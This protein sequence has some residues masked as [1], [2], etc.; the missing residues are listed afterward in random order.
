MRPDL[1]G[2]NFEFKNFY[3]GKRDEIAMTLRG[4]QR[5]K[6]WFYITPEGLAQPV[7]IN[8]IDTAEVIEEKG[9]AFSLV[10]NPFLVQF[11]EYDT[12]QRP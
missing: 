12:F 4:A 9:L 5:G 8:L 2:D 11:K 6:L 10:L 3:I 1:E 7:I